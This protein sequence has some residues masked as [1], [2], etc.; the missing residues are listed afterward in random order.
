MDENSVI[1]T[2]F[3]SKPKTLKIKSINFK[4]IEKIILL[5]YCDD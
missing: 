2:Q 4:K 3:F 1:S 5:G